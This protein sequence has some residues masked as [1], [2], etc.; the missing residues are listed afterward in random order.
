MG[1]WGYEPFSNDAAHDWVAALRQQAADYIRAALK[2]RK[3]GE[4]AT[5]AAAGLLADLTRHGSLLDISFIALQTGL[6]E[7][8]E[9][10]LKRL[11]MDE[12]AVSAW[13][14]PAK[15]RREVGKVSRR[16]ARRRRQKQRAHDSA[17]KRIVFKSR[18][19]A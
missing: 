17:M 8:A 6:F 19:L 5:Y 18:K 1:A 7:N 12:S 4:S 9:D 14:D 11:L 16:L 2:P 3:R 15:Y 13:N 10:A